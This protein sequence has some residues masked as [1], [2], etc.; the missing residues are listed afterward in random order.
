MTKLKVKW[1]DYASCATIE[2][3]YSFCGN[4]IDTTILDNDRVG[5]VLATTRGIFGTTYFTVLCDD[6]EIREVQTNKVKI[7]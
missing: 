5:E 7:L 3:A 6:G 2:A 4:D 1:R